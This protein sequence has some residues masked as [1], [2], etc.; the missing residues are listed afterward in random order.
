MIRF[1]DRLLYRL[2]CENRTINSQN[3][4][5]DYLRFNGSWLEELQQIAKEKIDLA[6]TRIFNI[7]LE[8]L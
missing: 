8:N 7:V 6:I 1:I 2:Q 3:E 4:L 5:V